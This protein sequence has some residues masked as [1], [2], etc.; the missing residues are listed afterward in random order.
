MQNRYVGDLGDF[1]KYG[2][3]RALCLAREGDPGR[4]LRLGVVW[5]LV[6]D[7]AHNDDGKH[8]R[9]LE[10]SANNEA[11]FRRCD[12]DLYDALAQIVDRGPR[13]VGSVREERVLPSDTA[14]YETPL[15][16]G[17]LPHV[18]P[19]AREERLAHRRTWLQ[20]AHTA[21]AGCDLVFVDPDNGLESGTRRHEKLGP[22]YVYLDELSPYLVRGQ[23][24]VIYHHLGRR[25]SAK[26]QLQERFRQITER[27]QPSTGAFALLFRRGTLRCFFIVPTEVHRDIL[28]QKAR[29]F[30]NGPWSAHFEIVMPD[31]TGRQPVG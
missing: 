17:D 2:L 26:H 14:F 11:R 9:Y 31:H 19:P 28:T 6:P 7:E 23:S 20:G 21:T 22:K 8:I 24:V 16:F 15:T 3:L 30:V 18:G 4:A 25:G 5:Y 1:G 12:P 10:P 29:R 27:L 13:S